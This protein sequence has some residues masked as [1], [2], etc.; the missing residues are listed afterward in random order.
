MEIKAWALVYGVDGFGADIA[1]AL[2]EGVFLSKEQAV[3]HCIKLNLDLLKDN[4]NEIYEEGW[5]E[6]MWDKS[7]EDGK[8]LEELF[9]KED[10][11]NPLW[12]E[13]MSK[14]I[15]EGRAGA[16]KL[17]IYE[18]P[19]YGFYCIRETFIH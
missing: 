8:I 9:Q 5:G 12:E 18:E 6:D 19:V 11:D 13:I 10:F 3:E 16:K 2:E 17:A 14:H 4:Q 7:T 15:L 1:P